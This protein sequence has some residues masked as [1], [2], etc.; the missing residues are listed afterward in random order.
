MMF[1]VPPITQSLNTIHIILLLFLEITFKQIPDYLD[2][3]Y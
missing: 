1:F 2:I 3:L